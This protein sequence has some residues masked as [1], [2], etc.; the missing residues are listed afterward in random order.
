LNSPNRLILVPR[1]L[2]T[3]NNFP[4]PKIPVLQLTHL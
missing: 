2:F 3:L 4:T 1:N